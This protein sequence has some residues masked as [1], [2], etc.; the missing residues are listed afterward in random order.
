MFFTRLGHDGVFF[1]SWRISDAEAQVGVGRTKRIQEAWHSTTGLGDW[2]CTVGEW[3]FV[4]TACRVGLFFLACFGCHVPLEIPVFCL[5]L[6]MGM[7]DGSWASIADRQRQMVM[8]FQ[9][10]AHFSWSPRCQWLLRALSLLVSKDYSRYSSPSE[11]NLQRIAMDSQ[12]LL[13]SQGRLQKGLLSRF[14][15][16]KKTYNSKIQNQNCMV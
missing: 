14:R 4:P 10:D 15:S 7:S 6:G 9:A 2:A 11:K 8:F 13:S 5:T 1:V 12:L 16:I 3:A